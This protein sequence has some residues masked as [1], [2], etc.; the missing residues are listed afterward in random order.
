MI[1]GEPVSQ[2]TPA[3]LWDG[4]TRLVHWGLV[5]LIGFSWWSAET[6]RM[7]WH[8]WSG[9][10]VLALVVFRV[11]WGLVGP[12]SAR[13]SRF[14]KGPRAIAA[15]AKTFSSR[16][17]SETPGH[18]PLGALSVVA[19][20]G[21]LS[22]Q[23]ITGLFAVDVDGLE[24]GP[25]SDRVDFETGRQFADWHHW[26]FAGLQVLIVLHVAAV[27]FYLAYKRSNLV[28]PMITGRRVFDRDPELRFA[29]LWRAA[30]VAILAGLLAWWIST[31]LRV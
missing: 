30:P 18:N 19:I 26:S 2:S 4:P 21:L 27:V 3:R 17:P 31:G 5:G 11:V 16:S 25:L 29:P 15:Y 9:Y 6:E 14:V 8:R 24:S 7:E 10:A 13:F 22:T 20:L 12:D 23:V 1:P 28:G